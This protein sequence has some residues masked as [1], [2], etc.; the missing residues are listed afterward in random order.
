MTEARG[1]KETFV[2]MVIVSVSCEK[3]LVSLSPFKGKETLK[4]SQVK[5]L[6]LMR[7]KKS[8]LVH[9]QVIRSGDVSILQ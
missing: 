8:K 6:I 2:Y 1:E 7:M 4:L 3:V 5:V 9:W